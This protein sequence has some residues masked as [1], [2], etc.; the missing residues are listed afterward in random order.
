MNNILE[1]IK[2]VKPNDAAS[3]ERAMNESVGINFKVGDEVCV[4]D[5]PT[6]QIAGVKGKIK[7]INGNV[8]EVELANGAKYNM[9]LNVLYRVK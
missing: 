2:T 1:I 7:S 8:G 3:V 4:A 6:Y 9:S 5:D